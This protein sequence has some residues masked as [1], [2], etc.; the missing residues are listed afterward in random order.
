[1]KRF[2]NWLIHKLGGYTKEDVRKIEKRLEKPTKFF[3]NECKR[4]VKRIYSA[5]TFESSAKYIADDYI[6]D[7]KER[8]LDDLLPEFRKNYKPEVKCRFDEKKRVYEYSIM[9][10]YLEPEKEKS[11]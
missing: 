4:E 5:M 7:L 2:K 3:L 11:E 9:L 10:E 8:L 6:E 1:M